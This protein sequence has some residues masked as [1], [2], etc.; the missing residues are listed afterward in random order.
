MTQI[1]VGRAVEAWNWI[2]NNSH[3]EVGTVYHPRKCD[4]EGRPLRTHVY[5]K[6]YHDTMR[7]PDALLDEVMAGLRPNTRKFDT[8][9]YALKPNARRAIGVS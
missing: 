1:T 6:N 5:F 4:G 9:M 7:V 3:E 8:R 2:Y